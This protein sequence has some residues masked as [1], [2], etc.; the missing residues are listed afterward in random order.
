ML[1]TMS[2]VDKLRQCDRNWEFEGILSIGIFNVLHL[3]VVIFNAFIFLSR[4]LVRFFPRIGIAIHIS[5]A[6]DFAMEFSDSLG[7]GIEF[8]CHRQ[9]FIFDYFLIPNPNS[10]FL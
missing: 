6:F 1:A 2:K 4:N 10:H 3:F 7:F 5:T 8:G 9:H